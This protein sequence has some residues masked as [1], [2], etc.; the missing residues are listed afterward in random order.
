MKILIVEDEL[1]LSES[2]KSYLQNEGYLCEYA[3]NYD[4]AIEKISLYQY[5]ILVVDLNL[6]DGN[7]INIIQKLK[8]TN[9]EGG[10]IITSARSSLDDRIL[11]L[12]SGADDYLVKPFHLAELNA[13]IK[14]LLRRVLFKG[15]SAIT[16][17]EI[18]IKTDE[19]LVYIKDNLLELTKKEFD[20]LLFLT[21]NKERVISKESIAE[22]LWGDY[23]DSADS[24]GFVY[25]HIKNLRKKLLDNGVGDYLQ[26]VYGVGYKFTEN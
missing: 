17:G 26:T 22:H 12:N 11:G 15:G 4:T 1:E 16:F 6:P 21:T 19:H 7:G 23:I 10:I 25:A 3:L 13:R 8:E 14:S 24:F 20:L 5:D 2:I 18:I 9:F